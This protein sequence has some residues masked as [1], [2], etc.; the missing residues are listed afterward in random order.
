MKTVRGRNVGSDQYT[1]HLGRR[2]RYKTGPNRYGDRLESWMHNRGGFQA[3]ILAGP[4][5]GHVTKECPFW[6]VI[7]PHDGDAGL[8]ERVAEG[9][10]GT[11]EQAKRAVR[12]A[13]RALR[14]LGEFPVDPQPIVPGVRRRAA[15]DGP[16]PSKRYSYL[17]VPKSVG[18][19]VQS[20]HLEQ[21]GLYLTIFTGPQYRRES[22]SRPFQWEVNLGDEYDPDKRVASGRAE[23]LD[24]AKRAVG[25]A[26]RKVRATV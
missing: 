26:A 7:L 6:W 23:T 1:K 17:T 24:K 16:P 22:R 18:P 2:Y 13:F 14:E 20:W 11:L 5:C 10:A 8:D 3:C 19:P 21:D 9:L 25:A 12:S 4:G 15:D